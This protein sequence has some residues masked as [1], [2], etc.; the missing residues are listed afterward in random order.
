MK[1][2]LESGESR[3]VRNPNFTRGEK[4]ACCPFSRRTNSTDDSCRLQGGFSGRRFPLSLRT[5]PVA[6]S[7]ECL[8]RIGASSTLV[9]RRA[10]L[11]HSSGS[12]RPFTSQHLLPFAE[13]M[14]LAESAQPEQPEISRK[15]LQANTLQKIT[16]GAEG[17]VVLPV[18]KESFTP[19]LTI[20]SIIAYIPTVRVRG[21]GS[22]VACS[23]FKLEAAQQESRRRRRV[24]SG[25]LISSGSPERGLCPCGFAVFQQLD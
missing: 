17:P 11:S 5:K 14:P 23:V 13:S 7:E 20:L 15:C 6:W 25:L 22:V 2:V 10:S 8:S 1:V 12:L 19:V 24:S 18:R 3:R 9:G 21:A 16:K 4:G